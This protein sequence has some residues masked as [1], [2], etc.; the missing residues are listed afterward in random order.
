MIWQHGPRSAGL[1]GRGF[2]IDASERHIKSRY[3]T[4][5]GIRD[6]EDFYKRIQKPKVSRT[7]NLRLEEERSKLTVDG[8]TRARK[9]SSLQGSINAQVSHAAQSRATKD[10]IDIDQSVPLL[11]RYSHGSSATKVS[12]LHWSPVLQHHQINRSVYATPPSSVGTHF[13]EIDPPLPE[14]HIVQQKSADPCFQTDDSHVTSIPINRPKYQKVEEWAREQQRLFEDM[15]ELLDPQEES[16]PSTSTEQ[17]NIRSSAEVI[18]TQID[19]SNREADEDGKSVSS[20]IDHVL[21]E[22]MMCIE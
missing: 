5:S 22:R 15:N 7:N 17:K 20:W 13:E 8:R 3:D 16:Q 6:P 12:S 4:L 11:M 10:P 9:G 14:E 19:E 21:C 18:E 1:P 2:G